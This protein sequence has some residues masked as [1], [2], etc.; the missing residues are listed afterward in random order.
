MCGLGGY[1]EN[2]W[3]ISGWWAHQPGELNILINLCSVRGMLGHAITITFQLSEE[4]VRLMVSGSTKQHV[5]E[6]K[7]SLCACVCVS[8]CWLCRARERKREGE[9]AC[10]WSLLG[11]HWINYYS[12]PLRPPLQL[13]WFHGFP[14]IPPPNSAIAEFCKILLLFT[15][16]LLLLF[17]LLLL[18]SSPLWR[19]GAEDFSL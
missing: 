6:W 2:Q 13:N 10:H 12:A 1:K 11:K 5:V 14:P 3:K 9:P 15:E 7:V 18:M 17:L 8:L 16:L 4:T 19:L